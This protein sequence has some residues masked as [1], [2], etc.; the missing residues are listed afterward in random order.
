MADIVD[1]DFLKESK[2][3]F[4]RQRTT[5]KS[6]GIGFDLSFDE[7]I[8]IWLESGHFHERG[9]GKGKY[10][11]SRI[12]DVGAYV[13]GNVCIVSQEQNSAEF[14]ARMR[15][16]FSGP[17]RFDGVYLVSPGL[18]KGWVAS[19]GRHVIGYF[20]SESEARA[21]KIAFNAANPRKGTPHSQETRFKL[22]E[23]AKERYARQLRQGA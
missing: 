7:W 23:R 3:R 13:V 2:K 17:V 4:N 18:K 12:G 5:A 9:K 16:R 15:S 22:S 10:V 1:A 14:N 6:R 20:E 11:M 8:G 21:A 19:R